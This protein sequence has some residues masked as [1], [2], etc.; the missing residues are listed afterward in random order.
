MGVDVSIAVG[1]RVFGLFGPHGDLPDADKRAAKA[2]L[3]ARLRAFLANPEPLPGLQ[4]AL[5]RFDWS[6]MGR[7]YDDLLEDVAQNRG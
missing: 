7:V 2:E 3:L 4:R 1:V 5:A 6:M